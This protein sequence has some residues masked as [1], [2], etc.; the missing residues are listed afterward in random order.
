MDCFI[1]AF[2]QLVELLARGQAPGV[3]VALAGAGLAAARKP[4]GERLL[5]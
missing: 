2:T 4:H 3:A 5:R 1:H